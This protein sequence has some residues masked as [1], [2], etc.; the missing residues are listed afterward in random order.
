MNILLPWDYIFS[1]RTILS[2]SLYPVAFVLSV[3]SLDLLHKV[4]FL[5]DIGSSNPVLCENLEV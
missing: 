1:P 4:N 2:G 3:C 5:Y